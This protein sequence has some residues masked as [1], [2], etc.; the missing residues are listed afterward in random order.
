MLKQLVIGIVF[1]GSAASA[2]HDVQFQA[3]VNV[4]TETYIDQMNPKPVIYEP[5]KVDIFV[6]SIIEKVRGLFH[7]DDH[8]DSVD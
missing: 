7:S 5:T 1:I 3:C 2:T 4:C 8:T 6:N